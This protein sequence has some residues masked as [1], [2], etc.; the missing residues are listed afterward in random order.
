MSTPLLSV[1]IPVYQAVSTLDRCLNSILS[2]VPADT[3]I[4]LVNDGSTD[5][6]AALCDAWAAKDSRVHVIH[7]KNSGASVARNTGL[8]HSKGAYIQF[9]DS[10]DALLPGLYDAVLPPLKSGSEVCVFACKNAGQSVPNEI[11][12][13]VENVALSSIPKNEI[14]RYLLGTGVFFSPINKIFARNLWLKSK[15][16][17]P[18]EL[19]VNEDA[20]FNYQ[21]LAPCER[22]TMLPEAFYEIYLEEGSL[23]RQ[24]RT[25]LYACAV[26]TLPLLKAFLASAGFTDSEAAAFSEKYRGLAAVRQYTLA[27]SH[28]GELAARRKI[29]AE[30]L[31]DPLTKTAICGHLAADPNR[32]M[33]LPLLLLAKLGLSDLLARLFDIRCKTR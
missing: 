7:Q 33:A 16:E 8:H 6:S 27:A 4:W 25:D 1:I 3:E 12:T 26:A 14:E 5:G 15:A 20:A 9:V 11:I 19:K 32:L 2:Q 18:P 31:A 17:F 21:L 28:P 30:L 10:D 22:I 23:S 29:L 13:P 24:F